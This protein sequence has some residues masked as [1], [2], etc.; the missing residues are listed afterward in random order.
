VGY[1]F[2][3]FLKMASK[4]LMAKPPGGILNSMGN[5]G[6]YRIPAQAHV[7][8]SGGLVRQNVPSL[9]MQ[10]LQQKFCGRN[11]ENNVVGHFSP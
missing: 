2:T 11:G 6:R 4:R 8:H 9:S 10:L 7:N 1:F 5:F 3:Y